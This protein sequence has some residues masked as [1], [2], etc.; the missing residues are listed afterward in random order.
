MTSERAMLSFV[1]RIRILEGTTGR[2]VSFSLP[3]AGFYLSNSQR[4]ATLLSSLNC[5]A[6]HLS[7]T[8]QMLRAPLRMHFP[9]RAGANSLSFQQIS[10]DNKTLV[11][12]FPGNF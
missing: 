2:V 8:L 1:T 12:C 3:F 10:L 4:F 9:A 11:N 6:F 5:T 7:R